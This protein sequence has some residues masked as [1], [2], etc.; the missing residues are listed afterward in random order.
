MKLTS[1]LATMALSLPVAGAGPVQAQTLNAAVG[2]GPKSSS[3]IAY[4]GFADYIAQ[5]SDLKIKVF[6]MS[7]LSM[8]ETAPGI[9]DGLA[10]L[11]FVVPVYYPA[12]YA[13]TVLAAN[14]SM[15][16][17]SGTKVQS[18]GAAMAGAMTEFIFNCPDCLAEY[19]TQNQVY[20]GSVSSHGYDLLCTQP[21][22]TLDDLKGLK[23]RSPG[24]NYSRWAEHHGAIAVSMPASDTYEALSQGVI[25]CHMASVSDL[26]DHSLFDVVTHVTPGVPGGAFAGVATSNFNT[27]VWR[28][29]TAEQ[30]RVVL[31]GAARMQAEMT[32]G[33]FNLAQKDLAA[34]PAAE[35]EI[36]S[37][38]AALV[39]STDA[40]V[41]D[42]LAVIGAQF[43]RDYG[44]AE[45]E[46]KIATLSAL[47]EKWKG[48]TA[49]HAMDPAALEQVYW[50]EI[51]AKIDP[52]A[53][54]LD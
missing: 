24:G 13:E 31:R 11:G 50:D 15:L 44:V 8:K 54:G 22:T 2:M 20:L 34:A 7:L 53:Y 26:S 35:V 4:E 38:D 23:L 37:P 30:R 33:Y 48:L 32:L 47:V 40:F 3:Y 10:D 49:D 14:L 39:A 36:L 12:E 28:D 19:K 5:N 9:R 6:S 46:T 43:S 27:D 25:D 52:E 17:T 21:V 41:A 29:L 51:F 16:S 1:L 45:V 42:D 18:P